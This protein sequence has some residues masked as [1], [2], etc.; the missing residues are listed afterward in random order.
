M[1]RSPVNA[2]EDAAPQTVKA[3]LRLRQLIVGGKLPPGERVPELALVERLGV[4]RT[5][6]RAALQRLQA[7]GLLDALAGGGYAV[8][9]F[10]DD[11]I[12]DAIE[13]RGT[14]EGLAARRA[15]ERGVA[16]A[17]LAQARRCLAAIDALLAAPVLAESAFTGYVNENERFHQLLV[18]MSGSDVI[19]RQ[20]ARACALPFASPNAF[21]MQR[22]TGAH[23][24]D[25]L[26]IAQEQHRA[27]LDAIE[28]RQGARAES[29]MREHARVAEQ[30]LQTARPRKESR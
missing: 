14:M 12:H 23:A 8:K 27:T 29:L 28:A 24:R 10:S 2:F 17:L 9:A 18:D 7:E 16:S 1:S 30:N 11:D 26:V 6:I 21:V 5:P 4:S 22:A 13:V 15:A 19:R 3:Q 20:T 25:V